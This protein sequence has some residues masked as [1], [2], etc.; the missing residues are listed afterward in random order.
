MLQ[1]CTLKTGKQ[2]M[3]TAQKAV[4]MATVNSMSNLK[5]QCESVSFR[6]L[7]RYYF[8]RLLSM[9]LIK[10]DFYVSEMFFNMQVQSIYCV[11]LTLVLMLECV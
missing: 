3:G 4:V 2:D 10:S 9:S 7:F 5:L 6:K 8:A 1:D 11:L